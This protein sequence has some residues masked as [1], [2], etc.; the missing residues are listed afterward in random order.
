L[1]HPG[2]SVGFRIDWPGRSMAYITDTT[3]SMAADYVDRIR[4]VDL[5]VHE[6]FYPDDRADLAKK[7]GHSC[8]TPVAEVARAAKVG[9]LILTHINPLIPSDN[10]IDISAAQKIFPNI[11]IGKDLMEV[12]F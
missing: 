4:G 7:Y 1:V 5:L 12:E 8:I 10:S 3:A 6:C 9:R 11:E 2:G